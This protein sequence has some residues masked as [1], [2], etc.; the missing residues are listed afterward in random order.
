MN[1]KNL[2][3]FTVFNS[4]IAQFWDLENNQSFRPFSDDAIKQS[5]NQSLGASDTSIKNKIM[6]QFSLSKPVC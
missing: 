6:A 5:A 4:D 1:S 2:Y 3:V